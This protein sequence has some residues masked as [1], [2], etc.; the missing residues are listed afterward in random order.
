[1]KIFV[2]VSFKIQGTTVTCYHIPGWVVGI[3]LIHPALFH[4]WVCR[5]GTGTGMLLTRLF[6]LREWWELEARNPTHCRARGKKLPYTVVQRGGGGQEEIKNDGW[7]NSSRGLACIHSAI[8]LCSDQQEISHQQALN[9]IR[10][11]KF[12]HQL[13]R[14]M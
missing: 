8:L 14:C 1:M 2:S 9:S 12:T 3:A 10:C 7:C 11:V 13:F 5:T 6:V 4:L